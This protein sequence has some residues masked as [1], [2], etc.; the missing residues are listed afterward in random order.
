MKYNRNMELLS[1]AGN[2]EKLKAAVR[3]GADA[4]YCGAGAFSL[5]APETSFSLDELAEGISYARRHG[6]RVYLAMNIFAFDED[7]EEMIDYF[8]QAVDLG[9][10]AVIVSDPGMLSLV[11]D[12]KSGVKIHLSTQ[13]NTMNSESVK[14]WRNQ[15][16]DRIILAR[17]LSLDQISWI[18]K[19][20]PGIELEVFV[21]GAMCMAFSGRCLLSKFLNDRSANRGLCTQPCRW[22]YNMREVNRSEDLTIIEE[23]GGTF[24]LNSKDLCMIEHIPELVS[25]GV[26]SIKIEGRMKTVYYVAA[27][28]RI[29]RAALNEYSRLGEAFSFNPQ[30]L[31]ELE[32]VSHRPYTTG[33]FMPDREDDTE[34]TKDSSYIR[35]YDF[36][37][38]VEQHIPEKNLMRIKARNR[39]SAGDMLEILDPEK[40]EVILI[41]VGRISDTETGGVLE[42][43]HNSYRVDINL[44]NNLSTHVSS[45]SIIRRKSDN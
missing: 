33:F 10:D 41:K 23:A 42:A 9:I 20:V 3:F 35:G 21:H 19:S 36:V 32:K 1:P 14:F 25:S 16:V 17:E 45:D 37:G 7:F 22:E 40:S 43:A 28:T 11:R 6:S 30:W 18:R 15:G 27:T 8:K 5:R 31:D 26:D 39:F 38:M 24:I 4:V 2:L 12:M 13:A 34:Y 44:A 29:Y